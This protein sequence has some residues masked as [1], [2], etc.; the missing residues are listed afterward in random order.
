VG[1]GGQG[2]TRGDERLGR[3]SFSGENA[4]RQDV[5]K[6][7]MNQEEGEIM[8]DKVYTTSI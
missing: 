3:L 2:E 1:H 7:Y 6:M 5:G 4:R 8:I